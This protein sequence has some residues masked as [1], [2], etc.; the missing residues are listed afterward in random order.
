MSRLVYAAM[1]LSAIGVAMPIDR[2]VAGVNVN[3][4]GNS[5]LCKGS[6]CTWLKT[7]CAKEKGTYHEGA[8]GTGKCNFPATAA[9]GFT[10][11]PRSSGTSGGPVTQMKR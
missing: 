8:G 7:A 11:E 9:I 6:S 5:V 4:S 2:A 1:V 10:T 3:E